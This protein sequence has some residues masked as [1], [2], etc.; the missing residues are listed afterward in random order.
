M[1]LLN[2]LH[3]MVKC[4][5]YMGL[6]IHWFRDP[7]ATIPNGSVIIRQTPLVGVGYSRSY[8]IVSLMLHTVCCAIVGALALYYRFFGT[9]PT[10]LRKGNISG[11]PCM[12]VMTYNALTFSILKQLGN[13]RRF[14]TISFENLLN[15][16]LTEVMPSFWLLLKL[17]VYLY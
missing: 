8:S 4:V 9:T 12:G 11:I 10:L 14:Y 16:V 1:G 17:H 15:G 3:I 2:R 5:C 6:W 7:G 13:Y